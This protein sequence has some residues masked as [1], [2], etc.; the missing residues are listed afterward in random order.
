MS[1]DKVTGIYKITNKV[2]GKMYIGQS[3]DI[4]SRWTHHIWCGRKGNVEKHTSPIYNAI[5]KYGIENFIFEIIEVVNDASLLN[6]K[7]IMYISKF[8]TYVH[9]ENANGYNCTLGGGLDNSAETR[10]K[11]SK[12]RVYVFGSENK[13][14]KP[15]IFDGKEY[16]SVSEL[17]KTFNFE[18]DR[19]RSYLNGS[20]RMTMEYYVLGMRY[21]DKNMNEYECAYGRGFEDKVIWLDGKTFESSVTCSKY[22]DIPARTLRNWLIGHRRMPKEFYDRGLR[23]DYLDMS[24]YE[25]QDDVV[26]P[27]SNGNNSRNPVRLYCD[28]KIF[29]SKKQ[30]SDYYNVPYST[31]NEWIDKNNVNER[32]EKL[33]LKK[34]TNEEEIELIKNKKISY[35]E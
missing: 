30:F 23:Y 19:I 9:S 7:E 20:R 6:D 14:S 35:I 26:K 12:N 24:F 2:N 33:G 17:C 8:N 1:R 13:S 27:V 31:V 22:C 21:K 4:Y 25:Y 3:L 32:F 28:N 34:I 18:I 15:V 5:R 10:Y 16:G 11:I 29:N